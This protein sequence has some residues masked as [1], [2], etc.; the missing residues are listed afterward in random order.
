MRKTPYFL[1]RLKLVGQGCASLNAAGN[2]SKNVVAK[3][4]TSTYYTVG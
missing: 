2:A 4:T 3:A 1:D